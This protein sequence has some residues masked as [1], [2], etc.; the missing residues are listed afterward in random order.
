M[1]MQR[2]IVSELESQEPCYSEDEIENLYP[3]I[4][5]GIRDKRTVERSREKYWLYKHLEQ[6]K[7]DVIHGIISSI[8]NSRASVYIPQYLFE[9]Q[10]QI[11]A[12]N[13]SK[14]GED[15][16][17]VIQNVDPLRRKLTLQPILA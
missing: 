15:I 16:K 11:G 10:I 7:G 14:E 13:I 12:Y 2:Q 3:K 5:I 6:H 8:S 1:V 9:M 17:L 4:D